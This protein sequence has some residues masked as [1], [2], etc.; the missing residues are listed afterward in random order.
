MKTLVVLA[1]PTGVGKTDLSIRL[2]KELAT[3]IISADSRQLYKEM[4]IGTAVPTPE[5]L[6]Q[7]QHY[8]IQTR[9][10]TENYTAGMYEE[11]ALTLVEQLFVT[12]S[13]LLVVGGSGLYIDALC[14]GIDE[15]PATKPALRAELMQ[16]LEKEGLPSLQAQLRLLDAAIC[17]QLDMSNPQRVVRALEVC[18]TSGKPYS[19]LKQNFS[20]KRSFNIIHL[21]LQRDRAELYERINL[22]VDQML[23]QGLLEEAQALYP[24]RGLNALK[25][26]GYRELFDYFDGTLTFEQ[27][28][29]LIKQNSRRYAKRQLSW[30][31]RY[32]E[33][34]WFHPDNFEEII[35]TIQQ[36][37]THHV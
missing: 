22:R 34:R 15:I 13:H 23:E 29:E 1:G 18:L 7:V 27:A 25:T 12:H 8:F 20:K 26:V 36:L 35:S 10:V 5:Q 2:A 11:D 21:A 17:L 31:A 16:R 33:M 30:F 19:S 28:V 9:S 32:E 6:A 3:P 24:L 14:R 4:S 37:T